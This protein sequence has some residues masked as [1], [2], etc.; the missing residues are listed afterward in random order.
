MRDNELSAESSPLPGVG[1]GQGEGAPAQPRVVPTIRLEPVTHDNWRAVIALEIAEDQRAFLDS[2]SMVH[3]LAEMQFYP[4]FKAYAVTD[5]DI[6]VGFV[7]H[8]RSS[9]RPNIW[10]IPLIVIDRRHQHKGYGRAVMEAVIDYVRREAPDCTSIG[11]KY[12]PANEVA[13]RLYASLGFVETD[14]FDEE[15]NVRAWLELGRGAI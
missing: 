11:L 4:D 2:E 8:G 6:M 14:E 15:G 12:K 9:E 13:R 10:W 7:S 5:G 3:A 1:E